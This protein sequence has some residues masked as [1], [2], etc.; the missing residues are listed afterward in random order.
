MK[1][2]AIERKQHTQETVAREIPEEEIEFWFT[3]DF[4]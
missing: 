1:T 4:Q 3:R 2:E